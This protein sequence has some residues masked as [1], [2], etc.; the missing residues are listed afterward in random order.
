MNKF[1]KWLKSSASDFVLFV[2]ILV[3]AN[4]ACRKAFLRFDLTSQGSYSISEASKSTVKT[5]TEPLS[6]KVFFSDNLP[7][8]YNATSQYIKDILVEYKGAANKN[9]TYQFFNMNKVENQ[10][11]AQG[12]G[13]RQ[14]QIQQV[15][16]SEVGFKQVWMGL[17]ITYGDSIEVIDSITSDSGFEYNLTTKISKMISQSDTLAGLGPDEKITLT[18]YASDELNQFNIA[19]YDTVSAQVTSAFNKVNQ[20]N[21]NR[22]T[23]ISK[24]PANDEVQEA[25]DIYGLQLFKWQNKDGSEGKGAFGL[26]IG[27]GENFRTIPLSI[28]RSIFGYGI[29][30]LQNLE[31]SI[32][33]S[34]ES[35]LSRTTQIGYLT[36]H[37]EAPLT[38]E[39]GEEINFK[40]IISDMYEFKEL[41]LAEED[42]PSNLNTIVI[43]GPKK[44]ISKEE[45]YKLDQFIMK[46][47]NVMIFQDP[48]EM[49]QAAYYQQANYKPINSGLNTLLEAYGAKLEK[50]YVFDEECYVYQQQGY[51]NLKMYWAPMLQKKQTSQKNVISK[52]LGYLI[53]LQ[54][55]TI[56]LDSEKLGKNVKATVL[57]KTSAKSW[58]E[59]SNFQIS[60]QMQPPYDKSREKA[61]NISV[62]LEG[63]FNSAFDKNPSEEESEDKSGLSTTTHLAQGTRAGKIFLANTAYVTSNQ[64]INESGNEPIAMFIRNAV[65]YLNG[66]NDLCTMRTK[67]LTLNTLSGTGSIL[68]LIVKYF[69]QFGLAVL[70][71]IA[72]FIVWRSRII[73]RRSIHMKYNPND[74]RDSETEKTS[75]KDGE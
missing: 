40:K 22:L 74:S 68:A 2:L 71:A 69:N 52:N 26:V 17:A 39:N 64:L 70:V 59:T 36:G 5:L 27:Y 61:E 60:P 10:K 12:Y 63:K 47:G 75:K 57:A 31:T 62:L 46:G 48:F 42:I 35:L 1:T 23:Y 34:L 50:N 4:I 66:N 32:S 18:L 29:A 49:E 15:K 67:G 8:P 30:G 65:D 45:L 33:D 16:N 56:T 14:V 53:F 9:F 58:V 25:A 72:G 19:G 20:K 21:L 37:D 54:P 3:L 73:R 44:E 43:N 11:I 13:L 55:G 51:G 41:K 24:N 38:N 7:A 6:V 28:Q